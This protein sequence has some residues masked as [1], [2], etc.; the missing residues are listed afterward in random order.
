MV[1][2]G[3]TG[4]HCATDLFSS[5]A[6]PPRPAGGGPKK[7]RHS[8]DPAVRCLGPPRGCCVADRPRCTGPLGVAE[9]A[10]PTGVHP[11]PRQ[12]GVLAQRGPASC[13]GGAAASA[14]R[15]RSGPAGGWGVGGGPS[16]VHR[17]GELLIRP[18]LHGCGRGARRALFCKSPPAARQVV[19]GGIACAPH[20]ALRVWSTAVCRVYHM[21]S[22][23]PRASIRKSGWAARS[24]CRRRPRRGRTWPD[25]GGWQRRR[26]GQPP[27]RWRGGGGGGTSGGRARGARTP[28]PPRTGRRGTVA[29]AFV[30]RA[31]RCA[32]RRADPRSAR[33]AVPRCGPDPPAARRAA[34]VPRRRGGR[35]G[36]DRRRVFATDLFSS[37]PADRISQSRPPLAA[38][39]AVP[40]PR[41]RPPEARGGA[42]STAACGVAPASVPRL[43][44]AARRT[45]CS[46]VAKP[47]RHPACR[48]AAP[49]AAVPPADQTCSP[50][51]ARH[52]TARLQPPTSRCLRSPATLPVPPLVSLDARPASPPAAAAAPPPCPSTRGPSSWRYSLK[53]SSR[54]RRRG[55]G[56]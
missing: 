39:L 47:R 55:G 18:S 42:R 12:R 24:V 43:R 22:A 21:L 3:A 33:R 29:G 26:F 44:V 9:R 51:T 30:H 54:R 11:P 5:L 32:A 34:C 16:R 46:R 2:V 37:L 6:A 15:S 45:V 25:F 28:P 14:Q 38:P 50:H 36:A 13:G 23:T 48:G 17:P 40:R 19:H 10:A 52:P 41:R 1:S 31:S 8:V 35:R 56:G 4:Q 53:T 20:P 7:A 27:I 49:A